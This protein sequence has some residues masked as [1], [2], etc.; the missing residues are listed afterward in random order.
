MSGAGLTGAMEEPWARPPRYD[1][2]PLVQIGLREIA[3]LVH[4][5]RRVSGMT[6]Q[7]VENVTG[8]DQTIVSRLENGR[9]YSI[10]FIRLAAV[11]GAVLDSRPPGQRWR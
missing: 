7:H 1:L 6:Q 2:T 8:V 5:A 3:Q 10:R 9:L 4:E 11:V